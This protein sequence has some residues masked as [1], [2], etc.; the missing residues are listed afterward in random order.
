MNHLLL[1]GFMG[2]GKTSVGL[3]LAR[4]LR[5]PFLDLDAEIHRQTG[6]TAGEWI[7]RHGEDGF[8]TTETRILEELALPEP[9]VIACGGGIVLRETNRQFL[10]ALGPVIR[11][12]ARPEILAARLRPDQSRPL[13]AGGEDLEARIRELQRERDAVYALFTDVIDTSE[14]TVEDVARQ[15]IR[16]FN[17]QD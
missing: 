3:E 11:L 8:R 10:A 15:I 5:R 2:T 13:L 16:R 4:Q 6:M 12:T 1:I 17:I 7:T 9:T 14:L